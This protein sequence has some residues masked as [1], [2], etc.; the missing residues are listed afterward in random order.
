MET[1]LAPC[2]L[3]CDECPVFLATRSNDTDA[4]SRLAAEYSTPQMRFTT[5]ELRC[6]GCFDCGCDDSK[7]CGGCEIRLCAKARGAANCGVCADYPCALTEKHVPAGS[8]QRAR[9]DAAAAPARTD[10]R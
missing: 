10:G 3:R 5:A 1:I 2:G 9:L 7:M 8:E 6:L 4:L